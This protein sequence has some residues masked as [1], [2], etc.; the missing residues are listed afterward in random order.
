MGGVRG[1]GEATVRGCSAICA[2]V[3]TLKIIVCL[4]EWEMFRELSIIRNVSIAVFIVLLTT[5]GRY[6]WPLRGLLEA[7]FSSSGCDYCLSA[8]VDSSSRPHDSFGVRLTFK[9][10]K[11]ANCVR[12]VS[13]RKFNPPPHASKIFFEPVCLFLVGS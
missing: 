11:T 5:Y 6:H 1:T 9:F 12:H 10:P 8:S 7:I 13:W 3:M 4:Q 2:A